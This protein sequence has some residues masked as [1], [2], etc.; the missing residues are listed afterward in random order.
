MYYRLKE[1]FA[2]RGWEKL[3][4]GLADAQTGDVRFL[5]SE[6]MDALRLC[7]GKIDL[8]LPLIPQSVRE[9]VDRFVNEGVV[10]PCKPGESIDPDQAYRRY[11]ARYIHT[12]HWSITGRCNYRCRHCYLSAPDAKFGEL[13]HETALDIVRQLA[14]CGVM[15]VSLTGGEPLVRADFW[16]TVNALLENGIRIVAVHTNGKLV[17]DKLLTQ[18][19]ERGARP[20]FCMSFDGAGHH[21]WMRGVPGAEEAVR[22]AFVRCRDHGFVTSAEMCLY[23]GN[24]DSLAETV[25]QLV[26]WGC[27][28][29]KVDP[30]SNVGAWKEGG[31]GASIA[32]DA[33]YRIFLEYIKHY[34]ASG[35]PL[36]IQ[37]GGFFSAD[38]A[39][40]ERYDIPAVKPCSDPHQT[41][42]CGHARTTLYLSAEGRV[43]PCIALSGMDIQSQ[44]P[45]VSELGLAQ[46]LT[47]SRYLRTIDARVSDYLRE[48]PRC[49]SC[50]HAIRCMGGC[51][52]AALEAVPDDYFAPDPLTCT[53]FR[54]GWVEK[55]HATV[56]E[57][58][59]GS[60]AT[61][62]VP[63]ASATGLPDVP[64][65]EQTGGA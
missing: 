36:A 19:E 57:A 34:Y 39:E 45:K 12:V 38:P 37:L 25:R 63:T 43:L 60:T 6:D 55:I 17:T 27:S 44:F 13:S 14:E 61:V 59:A 53:L 3:P 24:G 15:N 54:G 33:L 2:L 18:F 46:C 49:A 51:R 26:S 9:R 21:D 7:N 8:D 11:G 47:D 48:N 23:E 28:R 58:Q 56:Q 64:E 41:C 31:Y 29:L 10:A 1:Q 16:D 5:D 50:E 32:P 20:E 30:V 35:M 52:A 40:P 4:C 65:C 22:Q 42:I 62:C